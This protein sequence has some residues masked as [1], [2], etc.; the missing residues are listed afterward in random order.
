MSN[1]RTL[2]DLK[3]EDEYLT[4]HDYNR[5]KAIYQKKINE[6]NQRI[7]LLSKES[8][9]DK[10]MIYLLKEQLRN[11]IQKQKITVVKPQTDG[12]FKRMNNVLMDGLK[13]SDEQKADIRQKNLDDIDDF[14]KQIKIS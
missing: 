6:L 7:L 1:I 9:V 11:L 13:M 14:L 3:K 12:I 4:I 5:E 10:D 8:Y 2:T